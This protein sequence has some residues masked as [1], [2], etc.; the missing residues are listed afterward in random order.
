MLH[1]KTNLG[2]ILFY[3]DKSFSGKSLQIRDFFIL[4]YNYF[5]TFYLINI[6]SFILHLH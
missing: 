1:S 2:F 5:I 3:H 6:F 4:Y